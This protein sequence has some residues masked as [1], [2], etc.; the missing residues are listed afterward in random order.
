[1]KDDTSTLTSL[2]SQKTKYKLE[3][4]S[5][6]ILETFSNKFP[7]KEYNITF[8]FK[9]FTSLCPKTKQPDFATI[10]IEYVADELCIETKS[11]KLYFFACRNHGS[12]METITNSILEDLVAVC[13]PR[14]MTVSSCFAVRG[15]VEV[16]VEV[17]H[18][19]EK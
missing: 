16:I 15:G 11:L 9:E 14:S 6:E 12:F 1:M 19:K 4:P 18:K 5:S 2:G 13:N 3:E 7:E 8:N 10:K 17:S